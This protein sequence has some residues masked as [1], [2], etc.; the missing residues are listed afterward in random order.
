M[1]NGVDGWR[2]LVLKGFMKC[3]WLIIRLIEFCGKIFIKIL[4]KFKTR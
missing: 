3:G 4:E 1:A 2:A